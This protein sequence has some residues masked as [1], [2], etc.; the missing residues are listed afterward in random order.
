MVHISLTGSTQFKTRS[1]PESTT[2]NNSQQRSTRRTGNK[3][4][5][6]CHRCTLANSRSRND[7]SES[8]AKLALHRNIKV[9][10]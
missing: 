1:T 3:L 4:E 5:V 2:V 9:S 10:S 7:T 8:H 6:E